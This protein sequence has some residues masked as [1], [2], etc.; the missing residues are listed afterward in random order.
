MTIYNLMLKVST[1]KLRVELAY[2]CYKEKKPYY[3]VFEDEAVIALDT[4]AD[5][6]YITFEEYIECKEQLYHIFRM[7]KRR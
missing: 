1:L 3:N 4:L 7:Y 6:K 2:E 5:V